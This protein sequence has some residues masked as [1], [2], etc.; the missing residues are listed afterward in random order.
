MSQAARIAGFE[1]HVAARTGN[2][3]KRAEQALMA[4]K[5]RALRE[6]DVTVPQYTALL[7]LSYVP[8]LSGAQL[9][10]L[11]LV[12]PQNMSTVL[13]NLEAKGL[14]RREVSEIHQR[15]FVVHLTEAGEKVTQRADAA[16]R[17]VEQRLDDGLGE[18]QRSA[19]RELLEAAIS[20]LN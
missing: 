2:V 19:V 16:A 8:G 6:F 10:R 3:I 7:A 18:P 15:V 4:E 1:Q 13:N 5:A 9:A 12:T 17:A 14:I 11:G 20:A